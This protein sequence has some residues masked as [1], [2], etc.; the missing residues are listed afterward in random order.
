MITCYPTKWE[1]YD[2]PDDDLMF[3]VEM[4]DA[5]ACHVTIRSVVDAETWPAISDAIL[6]CLRESKAGFAEKEPR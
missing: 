1:A 5:D 3:S 2:V 6:R 4:V